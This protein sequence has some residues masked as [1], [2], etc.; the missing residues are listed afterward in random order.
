[1]SVLPTLRQL[2]Y[3][4]ELSEQ[5]NFRAAAEAQFVTQSTISAGIKDLE[6]LLGVQLVERDRRHV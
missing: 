3:L 6:T 5:L 1:M 4:V 2:G